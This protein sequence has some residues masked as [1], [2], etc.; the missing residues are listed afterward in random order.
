MVWYGSVN[1]GNVQERAQFRAAH[2]SHLCMRSSAHDGGGAT[3]Q[4]LARHP[5]KCVVRRQ[6]DP[7]A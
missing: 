1:H 4:A 7:S 3:L 2:L 5:A 6:Q